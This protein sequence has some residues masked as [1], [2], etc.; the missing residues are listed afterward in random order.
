MTLGNMR[1]LG[2]RGPYTDRYIQGAP[3]TGDDTAGLSGDFDGR[4]HR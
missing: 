4:P 1:Q 2:V 3:T